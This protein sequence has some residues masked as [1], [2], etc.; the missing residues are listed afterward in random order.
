M[1]ARAQVPPFLVFYCSRPSSVSSF[2]FPQVVYLLQRTQQARRRARRRSNVRLH[3]VCGVSAPARLRDLL[4]IKRVCAG[5]VLSQ[6]ARSW[7]GCMLGQAGG[8]NASRARY[9]IRLINQLHK[10]IHCFIWLI[11]LI[12]RLINLLIWLQNTPGVV[13]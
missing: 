4:R 6:C 13:N 11:N 9:V 12:Q 7:A 5:V 2:R 3:V 8:A 1:R 10:L